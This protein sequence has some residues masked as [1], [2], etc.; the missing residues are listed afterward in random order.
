MAPV[1]NRRANIDYY[2]V[3]RVSPEAS[4]EEIRSS[5]RKLVLEFHPDKNPERRDWSEKRIREL[6]DAYDILGD[7]EKREVFDLRRRRLQKPKSA[8]P[9]FLT[10]KGP[11]ARALMI[12]HLLLND[13]SEEAVIILRGMED[14][15]GPEFLEEYLDRRDYLDALFLLAEHFIHEKDYLKAFDRLRTFYRLEKSTK[16]QRHY[17]DEV[18]RLLKDLYLRKLP[19]VLSPQGILAYLL[20]DT[21]EFHWTS[22][23]DL[24]RLKRVAEAQARIGDRRG[25]RKTLSQIQARDPNTKG[26]ERIEAMLAAG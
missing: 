24:L 10:R 11:G 22:Q 3:L 6:I 7:E 12:L 13:G 17:F 16:F 14:R 19:R 9:F 2:E 5:F 23:E 21:N 15:H 4:T 20:R 26:L 8:E 25:A 1:G 18:I